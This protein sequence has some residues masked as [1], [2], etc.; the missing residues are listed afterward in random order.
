VGV[1]NPLLILIF[2]EG[3]AVGKHSYCDENQQCRAKCSAEFLSERHFPRKA[4]GTM[5]TPIDARYSLQSQYT[6]M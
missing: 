2:L 6:S 5:D 4:Q 3:T 1:R